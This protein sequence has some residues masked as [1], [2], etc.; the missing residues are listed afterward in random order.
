MVSH[1]S[2]IYGIIT[3]AGFNRNYGIRPSVRGV[4]KTPVIIHMEEAKVEVHRQ[5]HMF[6]LEVDFVVVLLAKIGKAIV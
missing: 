2:H 1:P 6:P 3:K 4:L 5:L